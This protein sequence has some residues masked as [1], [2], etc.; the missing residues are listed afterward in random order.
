M[1]RLG[2]TA[3]KRMPDLANSQASA[4]VRA[5]TA[6]FEVELA[7]VP[8]SL[9]PRWPAIE[10]TFTMQPARWR[11]ITGMT[12]RQHND[13]PVALTRM[14]CSCSSRSIS[15]NGLELSTPALFTNV[16][17]RPHRSSTDSD[18]AGDACLAA[19]VDSYRLG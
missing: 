5:I 17:M 7:A 18:H 8:S 6:P 16:S 19:D 2:H 14:T 9:P 3:F 1:V 13:T 12:V 4:W 15:R 10:L 11:G